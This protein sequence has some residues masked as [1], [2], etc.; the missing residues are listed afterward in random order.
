LDDIIVFS[1]NLAEHK[2]YVRRV[3]QKLRDAGLYLDIAK[4]EFNVTSVK[5]LGL[6]V[7]TDGIA[8]DATKVCDISDW[9]A[10]TT[11]TKV[12]SFLGFANFYRRFIRGY[13]ELAAPLTAL[14]KKD[15]Q[16]N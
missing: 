3:F 14:T 9:E 5:Y 16:F 2:G 11:V 1:E 4:C 7:T 12:Q 13:S 6:I 10:P 15:T 8:M